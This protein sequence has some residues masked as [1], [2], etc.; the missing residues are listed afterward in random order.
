MVYFKR[1]PF[2]FEPAPTNYPRDADVWIMPKTDEVFTSYEKYLERYDYYCQKKF[3]C[4]ITGHTNLSF[5]DAWKS[6]TQ[7]SKEVDSIFPDPLRGPVLRK[8]QFSTIS[9]IDEL[10]AWL[11]ELFKENFVPGEQVTVIADNAREDGVVRDKATFPEDVAADGTVLRPAMIRYF[12]KMSGDRE[13]VVDERHLVRGR[14]CFTKQVVRS[15]LKNSITRDRWDGA[16]WIVKEPLARQFNLPLEVPAKLQYDAVTAERKAQA[17]MKKQIPENGFAQ[18]YINKNGELTTKEGANPSKSDIKKAQKYFQLTGGASGAD[19]GAL[20]HRA[21]PTN[22]EAQSKHPHHPTSRNPVEDLQVPSRREKEPRPR[23]KTFPIDQPFQTPEALEDG[24]VIHSLTVGPLL[25]SWNTLNV[26]GDFFYLDGFTFDDFTEAMLIASNDIKCNLFSELHCAVLIRI[27]DES[28]TILSKSLSSL[29]H[30]DEDDEDDDDEE[31]A[32]DDGEEDQLEDEKILPDATASQSKASSRAT[33]RDPDASLQV[34]K[35][36]R[37]GEM[38]NRQQ[39]VEKVQARDFNHGGWQLLMVGLLHRLS[40]KP[41]YKVTC[42]KILS[43]LAPLYDDATQ[44]VA[45]DQY[46]TLDVNLRVTAL[47]LATVLAVETKAFKEFMEECM[48]EQT[49]TRKEKQ[50]IQSKRRPL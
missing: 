11:Y 3:T 5:W 6:E 25:E 29:G 27:V 18:F 4:M 44:E 45:A 30:D 32:D 48:K 20:V 8:V 21:G 22:G 19:H 12:V 39:W 31:D 14:R 23:L 38:I 50:S 17:A 49:E 41:L 35:I 7:G 34:N 16:P 24:T 36:H 26:F 33:S 2:A 46:A 1:K 47:Q 37:A 13:A 42:D 28:G 10:V 9:R 15:F 40:R 43:H